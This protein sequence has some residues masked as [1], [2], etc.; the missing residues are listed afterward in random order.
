MDKVIRV[1][2]TF[3]MWIT[4]NVKS[5][6]LCK[7]RMWPFQLH[8]YLFA[9]CTFKS[10][11]LCNTL[12]CPSAVGCERRH[13]MAIYNSHIQKMDKYPLWKS[14]CYLFVNPSF[15]TFCSQFDYRCIIRGQYNASFEDKN[16]KSGQ[17]D[18]L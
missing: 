4:F 13:T 15:S 11:Y 14:H 10:I 7:F 16:F 6:L 1:W 2:H 9:S 5:H 3:S 17:L 8:S 18:W 12:V